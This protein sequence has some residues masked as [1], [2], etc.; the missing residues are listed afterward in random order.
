MKYLIWIPIFL[1]LSCKEEPKSSKKATSP[2]TELVFPE[3]QLGDLFVEIQLAEIFP[4]SK[5]FVDATALDSYD[6]ILKDY[7]QKRTNGNLDLESFVHR[8][9]EVPKVNDLHF[10]T[11]TTN[12]AS[13]HIERLWPVLTKVKDSVGL[14]NSLI[15]L[16]NAY[17]VPGGRFREVYYWDSYFTMLGLVESGH[18]DLIEAILDNFSYLINRFGFIPNGNRTYYLSRSQPPFFACMVE[19]LAQKNGASVYKKY[20]EALKKEYQFWM[21]HDSVQKTYQHVV[22]TD[23][24]LMNRYYDIYNKPRQESFR[25]DYLLQKDFPNRNLYRQL[26][27]GAE[28]GWD[29][30]SRWFQDNQELQTIE[31][32]E[33]LP[34]DLNALMFKMET[35]LRS[36]YESEDAEFI[37]QLKTNQA[38]RLRYLNEV[39]WNDSLGVFEDVYWKTQEKTGRLSL[40]MVYPLFS[41]MANQNQADRV[42]RFIEAHFLKEG[43]LVTTLKHTGQQWDAPNGWAPLQWI[44]VIGLENYGHQELAN[45]IMSRWVKLNEKV[46]RASGKFVEKYHVENLD[47]EAGG[48]EYPLQDGF[49]WSNGVY[50][51]F[52]GKLK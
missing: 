39:S 46:F 15:P 14:R 25:E 17:I 30:S 2:S 21:T 51:A 3:Q 37:N 7:Q 26:R 8:Y 29:Y 1:F 38:N 6:A 50:L 16:P 42:A 23:Y 52:K 18:W 5:T 19:L 36:A 28:S 48:G 24:G 12:S 31:I 44:T 22:K 49:G 45:E 32:L 35:I 20:R 10:K 9:F 33:I 27:A 4:D 47:I 43:G 11:D 41:K 13:E 40:A 34:V